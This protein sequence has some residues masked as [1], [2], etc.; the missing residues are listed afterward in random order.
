MKQIFNSLRI[1]LAI[2]IASFCFTATTSAAEKKWDVQ[3]KIKKS[4]APVNPNKIVGMVSATIVI[5]VDG[6][7]GEAKIAKSTDPLL[8]Q[9]V[10]DALKKWRFHPAKLNGEA[11]E[12]TI[13]VP[14]KFQ[15]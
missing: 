14:F 4:V 10:L 5:K 15:G 8:E 13:K 3:P 6:T 2:A 9:P 1:I 11:I 12:C 7:I